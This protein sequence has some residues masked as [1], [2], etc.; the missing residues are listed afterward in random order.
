MAGAVVGGAT[1]GVAGTMAGNIYARK[2]QEADD[3]RR[4][5]SYLQDLDGDISNLDLAGA[6]ARTSLNVM[7]GSLISLLRLFALVR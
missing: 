7:T 3:N 1:G 4:L 6:A 5:A 2:Q